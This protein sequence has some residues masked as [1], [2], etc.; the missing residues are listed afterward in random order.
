MPG[1][2]LYSDTG[3]TTLAVDGKYSNGATCYTLV[4]GSITSPTPCYNTATCLLGQFES[5]LCNFTYIEICYWSGSFD[6]A[7]VFL[8]SGLTVPVPSYY[9]F[10]Q[11]SD[12]IN[13]N[14]ISGSVGPVTGNTC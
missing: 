2:N 13:R 7:A 4:S 10:I 9:N 5:D 12:F 8:D 6:S 1:V 11:G 14:L 3:L